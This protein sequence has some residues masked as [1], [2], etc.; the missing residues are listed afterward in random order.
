[1]HVNSVALST[2]KCYLIALKLEAM[3]VHFRLMRFHRQ[4]DGLGLRSILVG[5]INHGKSTH[6]WARSYKYI[7]YTDCQFYTERI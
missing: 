4:S 1:M 6:I 7:T 3:F 2:L 5:M